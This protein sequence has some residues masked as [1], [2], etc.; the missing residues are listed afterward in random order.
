MIGTTV[1][2][3]RILEQLGSGGMGVVYKAED[4]RLGRNV[5]L[6]FLPDYYSKD[7]A[8][9]KRFQREAR[10]AS[11]LNHANI[12]VIHDIDEHN[13]RP[14][15]AME[16]LEGQTLGQRI[17][18]KPVKTD[19]LLEIA[20]QIADALD[21]AHS[22]GIVHR[23]IKPANIFVTERQAKILDFGLAKLAPEG[24]K[25]A[26]PTYTATEDMLTSPGTAV[27][28]IAYMSPEQALGKELDARSDLFSFGVV[29]Y[30]M[31]T[32]VGPFTGNTTAAL[33]DAI[34]HEPV[35]PPRTLNPKVS[36]E[37]ERII[38]KCLEKEPENRYQSAKE[39][40]VDLRRL[41]SMATALPMAR[42][43]RAESPKW[44]LALIAG[45]AAAIV[46][47]VLWA[48]NI[49]GLRE[50]MWGP[51]ATPH[52]KS[53]AVL[54]LD[55]FSQDP[56]Q[57]YFAD[58]MTE[59]LIADLSQ[60]SGLRVI[61]RTSV[62]QYKGAR[63]PLPQIARELNVDS[64]V[65]G[66]V[67]S[68]GGRVRV[69]AQLIY[70]PADRHLWAKS[71]DRDLSDVLQLQS[72]VARS[73]ADEIRITLTPQ[74]ELRLA[75]APRVN[76]EAQDAYLRGKY[77]WDKGTTEDL[78]KCFDYFEQALEKD[79]RYAPAYVGLANYY[80]VLPFYTSS[81]PDEV[82]PKAKAAVAKA[83]E[84]DDTLAEAHAA[85]AYIKTYYDWDWRTG[86]GEF[87]RA[88][89]LDP[90]DADTY[91]MFSRFL[92]SLGR[93][94]EAL[95]EVNHAKELDPMSLVIKANVG[96]IYYFGRRYDQAIE[97]LN[98]L[99]EEKPDFRIAQWGLGLVYEQKGLYQQAIA[100]FEKAGGLEKGDANTVSSLG[101]V[102]AVAGNRKSAQEA[103]D[104]LKNSTSLGILAPYELAVVYAGLG[105]KDQAFE[106]LDKGRRE[107]STLL[108]YVKVDPRFE[109]LRSDPRFQDL[110]RRMG[111]P[112]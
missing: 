102:Y 88:L 18:G 93:I 41:G 65:E 105:Q 2:H 80:S 30:E 106:S 104:K 20:M 101:H 57:D 23:D 62:M 35:V 36:P 97:V 86:E 14:F 66:S 94:D 69:T 5:A 24:T 74:E 64:V 15:L 25:L 92:A 3:Y 7:S 17:A 27:G 26:R 38:L 63:K 78:K 52:I 48:L 16:L 103:L 100:E 108:T 68:S 37:L 42:A 111:F 47:S 49:G 10:A 21:A 53:L 109:N 39:L 98:R 87:R 72:E 11:A 67:L 29:L 46:L 32:G 96:V 73:I 107:R 112:Q 76:P 33:F 70:A 6:K 71:Y 61:S 31:A 56:S 79:P 60:I 58:G 19:A 95:A 9:L 54:P 99:L 85:Q 59:V 22:K 44:R 77:Y 110:I 50:R 75:S 28:T 51:A 83:I 91:H 81:T 13:G 12:C 1:S 8:A 45:A 4:V 34:L 84:L 82:F 90:N 40:G 43:G 89:A 55:N